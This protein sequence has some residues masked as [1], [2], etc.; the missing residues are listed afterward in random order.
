MARLS[1]ICRLDG[2]AHPHHRAFSYI[3]DNVRYYFCT[4]AHQ[5]E[6]IQLRR[7][8]QFV[9]RRQEIERREH[10]HAHPQRATL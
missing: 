4:E 5:L 8:Q 9:L 6:H 2:C 10:G 7:Q 1:D 3:A